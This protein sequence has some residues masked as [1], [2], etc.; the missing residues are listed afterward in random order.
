SVQTPVGYRCRECVYQQQ[1]VFFTATQ[2]DSLVAFGVSVALSFVLGAILSQLGLF[3][4]LILSI[5]AGGAISEIVLRA[6][7]NRR[8]RNTWILVAS[9]IVVGSLIGIL[10]FNSNVRVAIEVAA[11]F[12]SP[13][14]SGLDP[15]A[16]AIMDYMTEQVGQV[17]LTPILY[18]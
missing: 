10:I 12:Y 14:A 2:S 3:I 7:K 6:T 5:P 4:A 1:D 13:D 17:L 16:Q 15:Q 18:I 8:A 11:G 9:G